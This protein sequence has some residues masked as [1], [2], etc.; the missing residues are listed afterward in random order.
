MSA[1]RNLLR[2]LWLACKVA[3]LLAVLWHGVQAPPHFVY[4]QF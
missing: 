3:L 4:Q 2:L 1:V